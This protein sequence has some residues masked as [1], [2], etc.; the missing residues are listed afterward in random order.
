MFYFY[1]YFVVYF[2]C[3]DWWLELCIFWIFFIIIIMIKIG[4]RKGSMRYD[5]GLFEIIYIYLL[6]REVWIF[7]KCDVEINELWYIGFS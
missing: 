4:K 5:L 6:F 3:D 7:R 1:N 2:F